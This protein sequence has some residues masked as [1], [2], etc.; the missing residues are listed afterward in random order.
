MRKQD[1]LGVTVPESR[2]FLS[3]EERVLQAYRKEGLK[4][5]YSSFVCTA[6]HVTY[7]AVRKGSTLQTG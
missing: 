3:M 4:K 7:F 1:K 2:D 5:P 6:R